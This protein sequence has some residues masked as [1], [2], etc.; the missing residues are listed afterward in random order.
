MQQYHEDRSI[1]FFLVLLF[2]FQSA[3][4]SEQPTQISG[5]RWREPIITLSLSRSLGSTG[6]IHADV[7]QVVRRSVLAWSN[8]TAI[9]FT[10][11][12]SDVESVSAK[13][14]RGDGI[15]L[16]TAANTPENLKLFPK[17]AASPAAVTRVFRDASGYITEADIVLN[18]FVRFSTDGSFDTYDLQDTLTH[19]IGHL[20][21]LEHSPVWS[22]VM[23]ERASRSLGPASFKGS[24]DELVQVDSSSIRALYGPHPDDVQCCGSV[25]G[26]I[27]RDMPSTR[28]LIWIEERETGRVIAATSANKDGTYSLE[29]IPEGEFQLFASSESK[30]DGIGSESTRVAVA[31][32]DTTTRNFRLRFQRGDVRVV[33]F[34]TS[35]QL[36]SMP[37]DLASISQGLF[38]GIEGPAE[39][40]AKVEISGI[41]ASFEP[42]LNSSALF[43]SVKVVGF[44]LRTIPLLPKG[45]FSLVIVT[46]NGV[47]QYLV[48]SLVSR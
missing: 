38:L 11:A 7:S 21:G 20:L 34:G 13:G 27:F 39:S 2:S 36:G 31:V 47:K 17:Q 25:S 12:E 37:L 42:M 41:Q 18:P 4:A 40:I 29:G 19:E 45:E 35:S 10:V 32:A 9:K 28:T 24:R 46:N 14:I 23:Y 8:P 48:G 3:F 30:L 15:S 16:I 5:T 26:K 44:G 43:S 6:N 1:A 33:R 22:S